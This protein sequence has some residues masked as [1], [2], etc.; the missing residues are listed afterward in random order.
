MGL[1]EM[2]QHREGLARMCLLGVEFLQRP[3]PGS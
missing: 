3:F 2:F 1:K